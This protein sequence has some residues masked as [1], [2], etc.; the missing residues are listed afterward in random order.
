MLHAAVVLEGKGTQ[1]VTL[2]AW[3]EGDEMFSATSNINN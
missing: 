2:E 1:P 3:Q